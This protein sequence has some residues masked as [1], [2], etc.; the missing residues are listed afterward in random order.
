[1]ND[2]EWSHSEKKIARRAF[3]AALARELAALLV[4]VKQRAAGACEPDD[5][6]VLYDFLTATRKELDRKYD[7]RYSQLVFVLAR[8]VGEKW[9]TLGDLEG[10]KEDKLADIRRLAFGLR[11]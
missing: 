10:L 1:M 4:S 11:D 7:Y 5:I 2:L 9:I 3:D 6:W 8:L